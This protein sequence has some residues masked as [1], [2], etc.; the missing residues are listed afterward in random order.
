MY[1]VPTSMSYKLCC[2]FKAEK[3]TENSH[4]TT[5][6]FPPPVPDANA[7]PLPFS[8]PIANAQSKRK[9]LVWKVRSV[10]VTHSQLPSVSHAS[11]TTPKSGK[12]A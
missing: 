8:Q 1:L 5:E 9:K 11:Y 6:F 2:L 3:T 12:T 4:K 10:V 7:E